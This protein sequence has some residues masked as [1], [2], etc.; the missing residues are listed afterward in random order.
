MSC[1]LS[2]F[3][4]MLDSFVHSRDDSFNNPS[5]LGWP[6]PLA[7]PPMYPDIQSPPTM[8]REE[9]DSSTG[10]I[11]VGNSLDKHSE[12]SPAPESRPTQ[13]HLP[14]IPR[15]RLPSLRPSAPSN[16]GPPL[17]SGQ[18]ILA[19]TSATTLASPSNAMPA[20][21]TGLAAEK[22]TGTDQGEETETSQ[23]HTDVARGAQHKSRKPWSQRDEWL[24]WWLWHQKV[25]DQI[26]AEV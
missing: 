21:V 2:S 5:H 8:S 16:L 22:S 26:N 12:P 13:G 1:T 14:Q 17:S 3:S 9:L 23:G 25:S 4:S 7:I 11:T 6:R 18:P 20:T 10:P 15:T 24:L 19:P